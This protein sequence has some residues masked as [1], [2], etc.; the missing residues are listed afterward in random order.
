[1]SGAVL[2]ASAILAVINDEPGAQVVI[3]ALQQRA[4]LSAVNYAEVMS[5]LI[6]RGLDR[7]VASTAIRSMGVALIGFEI[8]LAERAG[9][10]RPQT[11]RLGLSL[12]DRACLALA[13]REKLP[14][15][16]ADK[17][18]RDA[19]LAIEIRLIR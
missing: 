13:E 3:E 7:F 19:G 8:D 15:F 12:A 16:T 14:A 1:M 6:E 2:D 17:S 11:K 18:W 4:L 9:E 10:L 5:K